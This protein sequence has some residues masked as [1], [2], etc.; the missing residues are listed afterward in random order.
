MSKAT[1]AICNKSIGQ[2]KCEGCSQ[3]FCTKHVAEHR[4]ELNGQFEGIMHEYDILQEEI[5]QDADHHHHRLMAFIS[6]WEEKSVEKIQQT[7]KNM[8]EKIKQ[9]EETYRSNFLFIC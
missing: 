5:K 1:C 4:R 3:M 6:Q 9:S 2:F 7:A 8:R